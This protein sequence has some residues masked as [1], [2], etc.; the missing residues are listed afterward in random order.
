MRRS[1]IGI[2]GLLLIAIYLFVFLNAKPAPSLAAGS[3]GTVTNSRMPTLTRTATSTRTPTPTRT[4]TH[5]PAPPVVAGKTYFHPSGAYSLTVPIDWNLRDG[6]ETVRDAGLF[7][8]NGAAW[9][10]AAF[11]SSRTFGIIRALAQYNTPPNTYNLR[12]LN[13]ATDK[14]YFENDWA[15]YEAFTE[16]SRKLSADRLAVNFDV[17]YDRQFYLGRIL[18]RFDH[19]WLLQL[20]LVVPRAT[21]QM[22]DQL[23]RLVWPSYVFYPQEVNTPLKWRAIVDPVLGYMIK[24]PSAWEVVDGKPG[25]PFSAIGVENGGEVALTTKGEPGK[26]ARTEQAAR[27]W[28]TAFLPDTQVLTIQPERQTNASGFSLSYTTTNSQSGAVTLLN[29]NNGMLYSANLLMDAPNVDLLA[30]KSNTVPFVLPYLRGSFLVLSTV[31]FVPTPRPSPTTS[32]TDAF[33]PDT[34]NTRYAGLPGGVT[35]DPTLPGKFA[36]LGK[37]DAP[38]KIVQVS[39]YTCGACRNFYDS[40]IVNIFDEIKAGKVQYIFI[41][42]TVTGEFSAVPAT[43]AALCALQQGKFWQMHDVLFDWQ[44]RYGEESTD[45]VRLRA[46]AG[47]LGMDLKKFDACFTSPDTAAAIEADNNYFHERSL[48]GTPSVFVNDVLEGGIPSLDELRAQIEVGPRATQPPGTI[49]VNTPVG[50]TVWIP[51]AR[52]GEAELVVCYTWDSSPRLR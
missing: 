31:R 41:P 37:P 22:L 1:A 2:V 51:E 35:D 15:F 27:Q 44:V 42:V 48:Q 21:P 28:L 8:T 32:S 11:N 26:T 9:A 47:K 29:G 16:T 14:A 7:Q 34:V 6:T 49:P 17:V 23:D 18:Y 45:P 4:P 25:A 20:T 10:D 5:T 13:A 24:I 33:I 36:Y 38:I 43:T 50:N 46:A 12:E 52:A 3:T 30:Q 19:G 39:S 40:V